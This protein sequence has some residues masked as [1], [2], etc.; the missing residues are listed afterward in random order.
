MAQE[1]KY[2]IDILLKFAFAFGLSL[3]V[4]HTILI[5]PRA[6]LTE[7]PFLRK[8]IQFICTKIPG[9]YEFFPIIH[10]DTRGIFVK[11]FHRKFFNIL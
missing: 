11:T 4:L 10:E 7:Y 5:Y 2:S 9:C 1:N 3:I 6:I 8:P